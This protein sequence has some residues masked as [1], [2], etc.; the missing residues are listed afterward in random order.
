MGFLQ[1]VENR[2]GGT[3]GQGFVFTAEGIE[4]AH[5]KMAFQG[6][7]GFA[8]LKAPAGQ[9]IDGANAQLGRVELRALFGQQQLGGIKT[10]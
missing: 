7:A 1:I 6:C 8:Q 10:S 3:D 9:M 2:P 5:F 4:G